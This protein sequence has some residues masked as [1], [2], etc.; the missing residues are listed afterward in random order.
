M[1]EPFAEQIAESRRL[2]QNPYGYL[3]STGK[4]SAVA[5][6]E[7]ARATSSDKITASRLLLQ[8]PYAYLNEHGDFSSAPDRSRNQPPALPETPQQ[9]EGNY[10]SL[11]R[12]KRTNGPHSSVSI[13]KAAI[14][15]Q[16]QIWR[17]RH[18]IWPDAVP[19]NPID[20]LDP[21]VALGLIGYDFSINETL[22]HYSRNGK[23]IE[24]AGT[25]DDSLKQVRISRRF[26]HDVQ[27]FTAAH[28][29]GHAFLHEARRLH[30]DKPLN[31]ATQSRERIEFEADKFASCFLMPEKLIRVIFR[32]IFT[33]E[34]FFLDEETTFALARGSSLELKNHHKG[35]RGLCRI[36][37]STE[38]FNGLRFIS[39]ASQFKVS[40]EAMAIRLEE[41]DLVAI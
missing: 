27:N 10:S 15:L 28:E 1:H 20:M 12:N 30:R 40:S 33:T 2:L 35:L 22:G 26:P 21:G 11:L 23:Q 31:G 14:D 13:E 4:Y 29:L 8:D 25:I 39:L 32:R 41:L 24:V 37:A 17:S 9:A 34:H 16:R 7:A 6:D 3:D 38:S 36:L 19:S 5:I 18:A